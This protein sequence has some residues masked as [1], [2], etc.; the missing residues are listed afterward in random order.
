MADELALGAVIAFGFEKWDEAEEIALLH[1]AGI[2]RVQVYRNVLRYVTPRL[3]RA[4]LEAEGITID[5]LHAYIDLEMFEG[6]AFDLSSGTEEVREVAVEIARLEAEY[7]V[8]IGCRDVILHPV[9]QGETAGDSY[10]PD[11]LRT[12]AEE[13]LPVAERC[14]VRFLL[15]NMPPHMFGSDVALL[16]RVVDEMDS[17]HLGLAYD[18]GHAMMGGD[19]VGPIRT[20]GPRLW[21]VH[22]HDNDG[23]E[24]GHYLPGMGVV[25][26]ED[27]AQALAE[28]D[29][30]GTFTLEIYRDTDEVERDLTPERLDYIHHLRRLASG[31]AG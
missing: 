3:V 21:G 28:V 19:A 22:L 17:P 29:Y 18:S 25:P 2:D 6:P 13:L 26:F 12:S 16:R 27:V 24:D 14:D 4:T 31:L 20:M 10:R 8:E 9:G 5:G 15:E 11:A 23:T 1:R 30:G 7:A